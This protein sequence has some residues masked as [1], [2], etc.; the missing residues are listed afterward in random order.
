MQDKINIIFLSRFT[1][2]FVVLGVIFFV[3]L[4]TLG[5]N[6][7][8]PVVYN[9]PPI[10]QLIITKT[11]PKDVFYAADTRDST[12]IYTSQ[13]IDLSTFV[14]TIMPTMEFDKKVR[15]DD[16]KRIILTPKRNWPS[17]Q[18]Y[19]LTIKSGLK[20]K[21]GRSELADDFVLVF[22]IKP[23]PPYQGGE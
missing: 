14:F 19:R 1:W 23:S 22:D 13:E 11:V 16:T 7:A 5:Q 3:V 15:Y 12:M 4:N 9:P 6:K 21:D 18:T 17:S 20:S 2:V 8:V 10:S